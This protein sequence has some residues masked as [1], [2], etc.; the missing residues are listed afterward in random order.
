MHLQNHVFG[1]LYTVFQTHDFEGVYNHTSRRNFY[2]Q[3]MINVT[4]TTTKEF[5]R[6]PLNL[7][8]NS[9][10]F[11][12]NS[13][14]DLRQLSKSRKTAVFLLFLARNTYARSIFSAETRN[15]TSLAC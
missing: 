8:G 2:K 9:E 5:L 7:G 3:K 4:N 6:P 14:I 1:I 12:Q 10:N 15:T 11:P 13:N